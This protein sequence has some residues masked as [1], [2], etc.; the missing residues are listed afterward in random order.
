MSAAIHTDPQFAPPTLPRLVPGL[1]RVPTADGLIVD[2]GPSRQSFTGRSAATALPVVM[3]SLDGTSTLAQLSATLNM[4]QE[5]LDQFLALLYTTGLLEDAATDVPESAVAVGM[6]PE[7]RVFLTRSLDTSRVHRSFSQLHQS[8]QRA[9]M[10]VV[11]TGTW[12]EELNVQLTAEGFRILPGHEGPRGTGIDVSAHPDACVVLV[13]QDADDLQRAD[14]W[15]EEGWHVFPVCPEPRAVTVGPLL[16]PVT[17]LCPSCALS[18]RPP[19]FSDW[20]NSGHGILVPLVVRHLMAHVGRI[21]TT[22]SRMDRVRIDLATWQTDNFPVAFAPDCERCASVTPPRRA[23]HDIPVAHAFETSVAFPARKYCD[24]A[25]HQM[26]YKSSNIALQK[27]AIEWPAAPTEKVSD[28]P[29]NAANGLC[30]RDSVTDLIRRT[31][32]R[33]PETEATDKHVQRYAPTGGNLGSPQAYL[34]AR[35]VP[36]LQPGVYGYQAAKNSLARLTWLNG[37]E[38]GLDGSAPATVIL[39]GGLAKV[40]GKYGPFAWRIVHL[41]AGAATAQIMMLAD[42]HQ[43][44]LALAPTWDDDR[45]LE[46]LSLDDREEVITAVIHLDHAVEQED[47]R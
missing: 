45:I 25:G 7:A 8:V 27:D 24:P 31:V 29:P 5:H 42:H 20:M 4:P 15:L 41:D 30:D 12:A 44:N 47:Q 10:A 40:G 22:R 33:R 26:H 13:L 9:P 36:G 16:E 19:E 37:Q 23:G 18:A 1:V 11:G 3:D 28:L 39:T 38:Q 43:V 21:G 34:V 14:E 17:G 2:G 32:G 35:D 6:D 46:S